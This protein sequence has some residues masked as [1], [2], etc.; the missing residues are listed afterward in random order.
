LYVFGLLQGSTQ[1]YDAIVFFLIDHSL[2][3]ELDSPLFST[4]LRGM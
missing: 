2:I 4:I 1:R 3:V